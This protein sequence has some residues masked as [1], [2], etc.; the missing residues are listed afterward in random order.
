[1]AAMVSIILSAA[2]GF[3]N[4][5]AVSLVCDALM[6][7]RPGMVRPGTA[8][9]AARVNLATGVGAMQLAF[10]VPDIFRILV[11]AYSFWSPLILVPLAAALL[12]VKSNGRAFRC[13]LLAGLAATLIW[14]Y[15]LAKPWDIDGSVIGILCNFIVFALCTRGA[16]PVSGAAASGLEAVRPAADST[17]RLASPLSRIV[18]RMTGWYRNGF[19][20]SFPSS[21][22]RS[23]AVSC[24]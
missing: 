20:I 7:L 1:M 23:P 2:D 11:L 13:A 15:P 3:L 5:A 8:M 12:G 9:A 6:P 18:S 4:G 24:A 16:A 17:E 10:V 19:F 21:R 22:S 14:N